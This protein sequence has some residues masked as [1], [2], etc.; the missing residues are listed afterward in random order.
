MCVGVRFSP[1]TDEMLDIKR[2][3]VEVYLNY[4]L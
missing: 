2:A 1:P 3:Y 4:P